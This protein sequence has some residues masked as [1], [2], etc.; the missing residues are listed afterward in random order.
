VNASNSASKQQSNWQRLMP[1]LLVPAL[2]GL[3]YTFQRMDSSLSEEAQTPGAAPRYTLG[4]A[5]L[6]RYDADGNASL[7]GQAETLDYFDDQSGRAQNLQVDLLS[8]GDKTW[9]LSAPSAT[10]PA[11]QHRFM[12]DGPVVANSHWP[13]DGEDFVMHAENLWIDPDRHEIDS[14]AAVDLQSSRRNGNAVG[15]HANWTAR[16]LQLLHKVKMSYAPAH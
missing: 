3:I 12:L 8:E 15:T 11:H 10:L 6:T 5:E 9:H 4:G 2:A 7:Y 1:L 14:D 13:D 16:T